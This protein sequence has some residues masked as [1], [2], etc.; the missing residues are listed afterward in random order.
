MFIA[1]KPTLL[2][3]LGTTATSVAWMIITAISA[4][5]KTL[6]PLA[7]KRVHIKRG[8]NGGNW[9]SKLTGFH[10]PCNQRHLQHAA[11]TQRRE[12]DSNPR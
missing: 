1:L 12:R 10:K 2:S 5:T 9:I 3:V 6:V 8:K 4:I 7:A 11:G